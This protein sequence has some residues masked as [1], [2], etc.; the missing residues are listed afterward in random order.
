MLFE[1]HSISVVGHSKPD[2]FDVLLS[3]LEYSLIY[4][5]VL[6]LDMQSHL[7]VHL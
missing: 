7:E 5:C 3:F 4:G 2:G 6:T 1:F